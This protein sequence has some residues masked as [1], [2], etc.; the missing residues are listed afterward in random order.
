MAVVLVKRGQKVDL[1]KGSNV[2]RINVALGWDTNR[3]DGGHDFDLDVSVFMVDESGKVRDD[4][5]F[6]FYNN[7]KHASGSVEHTG[8]ER[9]GASD[10]DDEMIKVDFSKMPR[11]IEKLAFVVTIHDAKAR[12]QNFG[13]VFN[14]YVR[15]DDG[16]S[17]E[18]LLKFDL[19]EDFSQ[20]TG[21]AVCEIYKHNGD[22]K[23]N[24]IGAGYANGLEGFVRDYGL[25]VG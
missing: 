18:Q 24:A 11:N 5:D 8:D 15:V 3:Y 12:H 23:F 1:T 25:Q 17:G 10:G 22:W 7:L 2:S 16:V 21:L 14:S 9:T 6:I 20:E 4:G 13:Q 19:G